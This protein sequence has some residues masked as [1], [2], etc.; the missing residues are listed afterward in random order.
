MV[1]RRSGPTTTTLIQ[2]QK[3]GRN[4]P[5]PLG[6][7]G[8][9]TKSKSAQRRLATSEQGRAL[10]CVERPRP[11]QEEEVEEE[12]EEEDGRASLAL[13]ARAP[14]STLKGKRVTN[15]QIEG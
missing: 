3:V 14:G 5:S 11:R 7:P 8:A 13:A 6:H 12:E 10:H 1:R 15:R 4:S 2:Q 9:P